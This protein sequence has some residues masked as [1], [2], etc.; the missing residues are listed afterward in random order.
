MGGRPKAT[1]DITE[2]LLAELRECLAERRIEQGF[3]CLRSRL[4]RIES[5]DSLSVDI[6]RMIDHDA[7]ASMEKKKQEG[8]F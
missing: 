2:T 5:L 3:D 4:T 8:Y 1:T 6:A 7:A